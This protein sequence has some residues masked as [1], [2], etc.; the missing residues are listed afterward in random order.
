M[1]RSTTGAPAD[2]AAHRDEL[3]RLTVVT[4]L[5]ER[6]GLSP[7]EITDDR[8]FAE[9]GLASSDA[10]AL[11]GELSTLVGS[12]LPATL[13]WEVGTLGRLREWLAERPAAPTER[14]RQP[15]PEPRDAHAPGAHAGM[16]PLAV[17]GVGCR[18]PGANGPEAFWRLLSQG[19]D[20]VTTVPEDRWDPFLPP[21]SDGGRPAPQV[22][23]HGGYLE[24][25]AGFDEEFFGIPPREAAAMDPQ[26][27]ILMEV[28]REALDHAA[29]PAGDLAG[30]ATGVYVGIS[31][32][33]Y[34][35]LTTG[36][37]DAVDAWTPA[38]AALSIAA[39]R[40]SYALDLRGP[41]LALDTACSSSLVATH[42]A[43]RSLASG[44]SDT[45][46]VGGVNL[47]LSPAVTLAFQR[48]GALAPHG[49]SRAF[50]ASA[51]GM[52]R[53]EGCAVLVL[54]RLRDAERDRNRVLAVIRSTAVNS[55]GRSNGLLAPNPEAQ[56]ALLAQAHHRTGPV[57]PETLD[58]VEAHGTGTPLGDPIE[59]GALGSVLGAGRVPDRPLL[60][61]SVKTN[62]GHLE[63][64]AGVTGLVKT[65][66]S[67]AHD[68]IPPSLHF[69][70]PSPHIDFDA[71]GVRVVA[72]A[73]PWPRYSGT[74]TAGVSSFGF[75]GTNAHVVLQ[76]Y[77]GAT[78][79]P[80]QTPG[81]GGAGPAVLL[82][83]AASPERL[84]EYATDLA[85]WLETRRGRR[86]RAYDLGHT[87]AGRTGR[88]RHTAA[89][90]A[91]DGAE[92]AEALTALA[93]GRPDPRL[94][95]GDS[96]VRAQAGPVWVFSGYGSQWP[97]M[98][99]RLLAAEP[100]FAA[101][102]DRLEPLLREHAG[103]SLRDSLCPDA[104][105]DRI[106]LVQPVLFGV[107]VALA[108]LWRSY[109][110]EPSGVL[111]HSMG[112]VA[113]AVAA[114][115]LDEEDGAR[116]IS[117]RSRLL[118]RQTG[119]AMAS[120]ELTETELAEL[121]EEF[122]TV[123]TAVH[124]SPRQRVVTG[125]DSDIERLLAHVERSGGLARAL[126]VT[127]AGHSPHV[128]PLLVEL[129]EDLA[130]LSPRPPWT[131]FYSTVRESADGT[132]PLDAGYWAEN[133]RQPVRFA[134]AVSAAARDG[135]RCFVEVSPHPTQLH[136]LTESLPASP[137]PPLLV[138]T[139]RRDT[140]DAVTFR[141][142]LA[143]L[144]VGGHRVA[145]HA[146]HPGGRVIDVPAP[147][148]HHRR[149][150]TDTRQAPAHASPAAGDGGGPGGPVAVV[151]AEPPE[152]ATAVERLRTGV[153]DVLGYAPE[154]LSPTTVLT[155]LGLDSLMA[156]RIRAFVQREFGTSVPP[157]VLLRDGTLQGVARWLEGAET[158][159]RE[160]EAEA[161]AGPTPERVLPRDAAERAVASAWRALHG[162]PEPG[163]D[164]RL[165]PA[166]AEPDPELA[167]RLAAAV[168][169][170]TGTAPDPTELLSQ[171][172][173]VERIA[174]RLRPRL[175]ADAARPLRQL[176]EGS[177][178]PPVF[179]AHP[180]GGDT[181][182]YLPLSRRLR[183]TGRPCYGLERLPEETGVGERAR[184]Y[185]R[186]V[187][188]H[189][190]RGPLILGGWSYGGMLAQEAARLLTEQGR[191]VPALILIDTVLPL[192]A[193]PVSPLKEAE[194]RF[195]AF[196][197]YVEHTYGAP[198]PLDYEALSL[199]DDAG[200]IDLV[201]KA[202]EQAVDPPGA[203][204][205]HQRT[206]Y[207]DL[208]SGERHTPRPY[209]GN[210]LLLRATEA[211]PHSVRDARY[212]RGGPGDEALGWD[213][214][215]SELTVVPVAGHHLSLLDPPA[216]D[217]L[218]GH[219]ADYLADR[220]E[221]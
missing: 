204:L 152:P 185:A 75:G 42:H 120:V 2:G 163:A 108:E 174:E 119:G 57:P 44:E 162:G 122:P 87:L 88:G 213:A 24:D 60:I 165:V 159:A 113:A 114:G 208:R 141:S 190:P 157:A 146:L 81:R 94:C 89:L 132:G 210:T 140:D 138:P 35:Q 214:W 187:H 28:A 55:D 66:L 99:H 220:V 177:G 47:L 79:P 212:E 129:T 166:D 37:L 10:V 62:T 134:Q 98:G 85:G 112:E 65:V 160:E 127:V 199:L 167:R 100:A 43:A 189:Q 36:A 31:G 110:V 209:P 186:L 86:A 68:E 20:A 11:A 180:A 93:E 158:T 77:T 136:P 101:A 123:Q 126:P 137:R 48:A 40:L 69:E 121:A 205:E 148:W 39:N 106:D 207:L 105:L 95:V 201:V 145:H 164:E 192:P 7:E 184:A 109:G 203:V 144:R 4:R 15:A 74:A 116:V 118:S 84:R 38:G 27:R 90:V 111:G 5:C 22:S 64:A 149:H 30:T 61:G 26:Q 117:V 9:Y 72:D 156:A 82:L 33:E 59:A 91:H 32:N 170:R 176:T 154:Q 142:A 182:V 194:R 29:I 217:L 168:A 25:I 147:R 143:A 50:D 46:L 12:T 175:E 195:A 53:G 215:C 133:L 104:A 17:V 131:R 73:E 21:E 206:S 70:Q 115:A 45:A 193:P 49:R 153:A 1:T 178:G 179:W 202:L 6:Y 41:S 14:P 128:E 200:Q 97:G 13:L 155:D 211:A 102:I 169:E 173:T 63:A 71:L 197:E 92:A 51:E 18:L 191:Q 216:V 221:G 76:E 19:R 171:P 3:L 34:A 56:R 124:A 135:H 52:V 196:A 183:G 78:P 103:V 107:Q 96:A 83:D 219:I 139:L 54:K 16:E 150:W 181:A 125:S 23:E 58:Y 8:P 130:G 67:L 198:L 188:E 172:A 80:P 161:A 151:R 218:S